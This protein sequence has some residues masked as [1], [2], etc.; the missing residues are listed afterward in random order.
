M[1]TNNMKADLTLRNSRNPWLGHV[2]HL[3]TRH[4]FIWV[5]L[6]SG[7]NHGRGWFEL[8]ITGSLITIRTVDLLEIVQQLEIKSDIVLNLNI[9]Y[10]EWQYCITWQNIEIYWNFSLRHFQLE[11]GKISL[12]CLFTCYLIITCYTTVDVNIASVS[13]YPP[14]LLDWLTLTIHWN[15][16]YRY[17]PSNM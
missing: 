3:P 10:G 17:N 1:K 2:H 5:H 15:L 14:S 6:S 9:V 12:N 13:I 4:Y 16:E 11:P 7:C 8:Q